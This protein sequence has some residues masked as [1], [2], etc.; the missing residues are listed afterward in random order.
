M[1]LAVVV[2]VV[3]V[4]FQS[5]HHH[6]CHHIATVFINIK[7][8]FSGQ[9]IPTKVSLVVT[10][11]MDC[12]LLGE[13]ILKTITHAWQSLLLPSINT[14]QPASRIIPC[15]ATIYGMAISAPDVR[16]H[17]WPKLVISRIDMNNVNII[18]G[19]ELD[20][21]GE[22]NDLVVDPIEP[23]TTESINCL[24]HGYTA[25]SNQFVIA[26]YDFCDPAS[27]SAVKKLH[28]DVPVICNGS[29]DA[30]AVWFKLQLDEDISI[31]TGQ[32]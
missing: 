16:N 32:F 6:N 4:P 20:P 24:H 3:V 9:D 21:D 30:I 8:F 5:Y 31:S 22:Y 10:E 28:F 23:Y 1:V 27:L 25:L 29:L 13:G 19:D 17:C 15:A 11:T 7:T 12:G 26:E 2:V 14:N 18:G